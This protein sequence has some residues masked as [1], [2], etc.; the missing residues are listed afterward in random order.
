MLLKRTACSVCWKQG[1]NLLILNTNA[2]W[3][4]HRLNEYSNTF[5]I[6]ISEK[7]E[8][9][10]S[11]SLRFF[12]H[13]S[14]GLSKWHCTICIFRY[15]TILIER[16][17]RIIDL[18]YYADIVIDQQT[19]IVLEDLSKLSDKQV[20]E[21]VVMKITALSKSYTFCWVLLHFS[22][23]RQEYL[24]LTCLN[25][26]LFINCF[27]WNLFKPLNPWILFQSSFKSAKCSILFYSLKFCQ[28]TSIP[29]SGSTWEYSCKNFC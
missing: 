25:I 6:Q 26:P 12:F 4:F 11:S 14:T 1:S 20:M 2:S 7:S 15:N 18:R 21:S 29:I 19:G 8:L 28:R 23:P 22:N 17:Y 13:P 24:N 9:P 10:S 16:D 27:T 5:S 3:I